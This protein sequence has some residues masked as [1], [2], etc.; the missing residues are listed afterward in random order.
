MRK[1]D[2]KSWSG[3]V[4]DSFA[5]HLEYEWRWS[6]LHL[7][8][9]GYSTELALASRGAFLF[10]FF[11]S[12]IFRRKILLPSF[13]KYKF[14][15]ISNS[16][17]F[18][19]YINPYKENCYSENILPLLVWG[20]WL[21]G[22]QKLYWKNDLDQF[23][24]HFSND[25]K[26]LFLNLSFRTMSHIYTPLYFGGFECIY[27]EGCAWRG[28]WWTFELFHNNFIWVFIWTRY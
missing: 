6:F 28:G 19:L 5:F 3:A 1:E 9:W 11:F 25:L 2:E 12:L 15:Q 23:V 18:K 17:V 8:K 10:F 24:L 13:I 7:D 27:C 4:E 22:L 21:R 16:S 26:Y 14:W 20:K